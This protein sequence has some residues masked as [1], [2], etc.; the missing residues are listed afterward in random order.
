[1]I[2][3]VSPLEM[4]FLSDKISDAVRITKEFRAILDGINRKSSEVNTWLEYG[5]SDQDLELWKKITNNE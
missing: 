4:A 1:M 2:F 5:I 3:S